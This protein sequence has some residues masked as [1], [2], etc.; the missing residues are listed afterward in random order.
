MLDKEGESGGRGKNESHSISLTHFG[1][2]QLDLIL[3][4]LQKGA[5]RYFVRY[6]GR[7]DET[8]YAF[9]GKLL[10]GFEV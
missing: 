9:K 7:F 2:S 1:T 4:V 10:A 3:Q 6:S 8:G 5:H